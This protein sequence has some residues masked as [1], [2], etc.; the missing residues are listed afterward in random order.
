MCK[1]AMVFFL[2]LFFFFFLRF[3]MYTE[4]CLRVC[5]QARRDNRSHYRC[6]WATMWLLGIEL[7][8][9]GRADSALNLSHLFSPCNGVLGT[10]STLL[11]ASQS[12]G[13]LRFHLDVQSL[14]AKQACLLLQKDFIL[15]S[16][17]SLIFH[18]LQLLVP[19]RSVWV[20]WLPY[21][22]GTTLSM[23]SS[24]MLCP[25]QISCSPTLYLASEL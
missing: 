9:S 3:I 21:Y 8:I 17:I 16:I 1:A 5:L 6:F 7:R 12:Y 15:P 20:A 11:P 4:F 10:I 19:L 23:S 24:I 13:T 25:V 2:F 14:L 22:L 18:S